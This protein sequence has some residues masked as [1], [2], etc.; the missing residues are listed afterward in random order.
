MIR[1][2]GRLEFGIVIAGMLIC[3]SPP[4]LPAHAMQNSKRVEQGF[5]SIPEDLRPGSFDQL[6][7]FVRF[8][9]EGRWDGMYDLSIE[10]IKKNGLSREEFVKTY[11]RG[12]AYTYRFVAFEA[13]GAILIGRS[14]GDWQW[15]FEIDGCATYR[16]KGWT[17]HPRA[18]LEADRWK[19]RWYF[20]QVSSTVRY[21]DGPEIPCNMR[22][23]KRT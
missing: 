21:I 1:C 18:G 22:H 23:R 15:Q 3:L 14:E 20:S 4:F 2:R 9:A 7:R 10:N 5:E 13:T 17:E 12:E 16:S 8:Q 6:E 19:G 11:K